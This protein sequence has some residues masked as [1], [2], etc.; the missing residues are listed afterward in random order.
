MGSTVTDG[1]PAVTSVTAATIASYHPSIVPTTSWSRPRARAMIDAASGP[2]VV[3][4][5]AGN[6]GGKL[7]RHQFHLRQIAS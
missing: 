7:G 3:E 2:G 6:Y 5:T 4:I 1:V